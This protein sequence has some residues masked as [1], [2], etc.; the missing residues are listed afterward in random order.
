MI[1]RVVNLRWS[2]HVQEFQ[3]GDN[4]FAK[5]DYSQEV[6]L[7]ENL[8]QLVDDIQMDFKKKAECFKNHVILETGVKKGKPTLTHY[9]S[10]Y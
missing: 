1:L 4:K 10:W 5:I 3:T 8:D 2:L 6:V 9:F 7:V